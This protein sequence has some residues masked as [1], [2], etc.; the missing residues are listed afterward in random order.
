M[1]RRVAMTFL[2]ILAGAVLAGSQQPA[3]ELPDLERTG[4]VVPWEDFKLIL[5]EIRRPQPTPVVPPPP[6]RLR[7][8]GV[9]CDRGRE[10]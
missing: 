2:A 1:S 5:E 9:R 6:G 3:A 4:V 8:L 7:A 10:R